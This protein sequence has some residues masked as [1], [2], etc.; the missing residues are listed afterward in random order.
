MYLILFTH[1]KAQN[2]HLRGC[3]MGE[4]NECGHRKKTVKGRKEEKNERAHFLRTEN[5][6]HSKYFK[7]K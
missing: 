4:K 2:K 1:I 3:L 5:R 7:C 6:F